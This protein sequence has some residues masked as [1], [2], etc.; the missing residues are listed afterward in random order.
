M[1]TDASARK[2]TIADVFTEFTLYH[3]I[4][5]ELASA[6]GV[7]AILGQTITALSRHPMIG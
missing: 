3:Q 1:D 5:A 6:V 2:V 4:T 7:T